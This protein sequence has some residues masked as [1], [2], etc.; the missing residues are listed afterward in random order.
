MLVKDFKHSN[1]TNVQYVLQSM[2]ARLVVAKILV[3]YDQLSHTH[4]NYCHL[5]V[6]AFGKRMAYQ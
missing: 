1:V 5:L 3:N 2:G 4:A 6:G